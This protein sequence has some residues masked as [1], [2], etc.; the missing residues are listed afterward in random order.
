MEDTAEQSVKEQ[1]DFL[2]EQREPSPEQRMHLREQRGPARE[3][4][5]RVPPGS[6]RALTRAARVPSLLRVLN[7]GLVE[8]PGLVKE[9]GEE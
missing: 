2:W 3:G 8:D 5:A 7:L 1:R 9:V 6:A 4:A